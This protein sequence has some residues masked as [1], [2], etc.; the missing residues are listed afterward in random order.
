MLGGMLIK[1]KDT[2]LISPFAMHRDGRW[3]DN[4][5]EFKPERWQSLNDS[6]PKYAYMPFGGGARVC[7]GNH[8]ALMEASIVL[9]TLL[10]RYRFSSLQESNLRRALLC[11][12]AGACSCTLRPAD[13]AQAA[14][15]SVF[16]TA[17]NLQQFLFRYRKSARSGWCFRI[18]AS[19]SLRRKAHG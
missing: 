18:C 15:S 17:P 14:S 16:L 10:R 13:W 3:F 1:K 2:I 6:L 9:R 11:G 19:N 7:V 4:P 12:R 8:F 5:L